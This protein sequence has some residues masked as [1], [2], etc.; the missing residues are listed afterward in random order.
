VVSFFKKRKTMK[1]ALLIEFLGTFFLILTIAMSSSALAIAAILMAWVYIGGY[2]SGAHYNPAVSFA[3]ALSGK[4]NYHKFMWYSIVQVLGGVAAFAFTSF[5]HGQIAIPE[6]GQG[7]SFLQG[8]IVEALLA[9]VF[10]LVV[11]VVSTSQ[12]FK[13]SH[14]F[15]FAIGFTIPALLSVGGPISGGLFNPAL[16]LGANLF[17]AVKGVHMVPGHLVMYVGGAL[18]GGFLAAYAFRYFILDEER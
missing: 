12:R 5:L 3:A 7:V 4:I 14:V 15:G 6:P 1:K 10:A 13:G 8:F 16:A 17:G 9:F 18:A 11:L 2:I